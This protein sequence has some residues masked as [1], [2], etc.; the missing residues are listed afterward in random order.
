MI[1]QALAAPDRTAREPRGGRRAG[2]RPAGPRAPDLA[3]LVCGDRLE[4]DDG[5]VWRVV[6]ATARA[7]R[8]RM[9]DGQHLW[10]DHDSL[11]GQLADE[12]IRVVRA[13]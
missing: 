5:Q 1:H 2:E 13:D 7:L 4:H 12:P 10:V 8:V 6:G 3:S 9:P 11:R